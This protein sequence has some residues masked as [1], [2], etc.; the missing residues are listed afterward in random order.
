MIQLDVQQ[1]E[2]RLT[3]ECL[4]VTRLEESLEEYRNKTSK[5]LFK[6]FEK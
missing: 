5:K 4:K 1:K 6:T 3:E 2:N